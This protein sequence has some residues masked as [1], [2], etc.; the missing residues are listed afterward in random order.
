M[1]EQHRPVPEAG[2]E[3]QH[4]FDKPR[5][6]QF[7]FRAFYVLCGVLVLLDFVVHRH[8]THPWERFLTFYPAYGFV[9]I[10]FL[11]YVAKLLRRI[12]MR[13]EDYYDVD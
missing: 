5:N 1:S 11:V 2:D 9:G 3:R 8:E 13:P 7:L 10:V 4:F 12:V 6:V